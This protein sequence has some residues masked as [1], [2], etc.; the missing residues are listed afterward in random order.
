VGLAYYYLFG[1]A[2]GSCPITA[3]L[4]RTMTYTAIIGALFWVAISTADEKPPRQEEAE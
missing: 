4:P 3:S 1:C 2:T